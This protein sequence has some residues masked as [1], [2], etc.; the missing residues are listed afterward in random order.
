MVEEQGEGSGS[1]GHL[2]PFPS[3]HLE[4]CLSVFVLAAEWV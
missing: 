2:A 1:H 3:F 4:A